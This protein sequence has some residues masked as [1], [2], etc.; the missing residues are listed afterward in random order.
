MVS[1]MS[2]GVGHRNCVGDTLVRWFPFTRVFSN[3]SDWKGE[4]LNL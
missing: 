4:Q 2:K 3:I 1:M